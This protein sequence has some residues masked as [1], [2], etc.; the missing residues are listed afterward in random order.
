MG[1]LDSLREGYQRLRLQTRFALH[2]VLLVAVLFP[3]DPAVLLIQES[4]I[5]ATA[6]RRACIW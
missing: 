6:R 2:L 1:W 4:A 5:L 3:P